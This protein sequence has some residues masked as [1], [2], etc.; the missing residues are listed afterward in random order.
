MKLM[1][2]GPTA[3]RQKSIEAM[4]MFLTNPDLDP[5]YTFFHRSV[6]KK[7]SDL[8]HTNCRSI[9][10]LGE[11]IMG[12]EA[13]VVSLMEKNDRVL[14]LSNGFF[15]AGF[16]DYV[17]SYGG[18]GVLY[19]IAYDKTFDLDDLEAF[20]E[21]NGPFDLATFV[22]CETP[23]GVTNDISAI[24]ALLKAKGMMTIV[25]GVSSV[26]GERIDFDT[27]HCDI[28]IGGTQK[29]I[30]APTGLTLLTLSKEAE[31]KIGER[32]NITGYYLNLKNYLAYKG[33]FDFPYTMNENLV[34]ALNA[35][36]EEIS[37][38]DFAAVHER[39]AT[40]VRQAVLSS[41]LTLYPKEAFSNTLTAVRLPEHVKAPV[42]MDKLKEEGF[43][44]SGSM[45]DLKDSVIRIGHMGNNNA[46]ED[47]VNLFTAMDK[48]FQ[49]L[50]CRLTSSLAENFKNAFSK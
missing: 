28:L 6:E 3:V 2:A 36:L 50:G 45:G 39:F 47:F 35:A 18:E 49:D 22:H 5:A 27:C 37:L 20:I 24:C 41:G 42:F 15:G 13:A 44:I 23:T 34:Y 26:L 33:D 16:M 21:A 25:D 46:Y 40:A 31:A 10:M 7:Y 38:S 48:V 43:L 11:A 12:L 8:L 30:S 9:I 14:V 29:A 17:K 32:D 1:C 19:E 4:G